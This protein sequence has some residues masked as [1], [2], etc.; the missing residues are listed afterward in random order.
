M[1]IVRM[2]KKFQQPPS[3]FYGD[4]EE[5]LGVGGSGVSSNQGKKLKGKEME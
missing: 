3:L 1:A 5:V 4:A 2:G